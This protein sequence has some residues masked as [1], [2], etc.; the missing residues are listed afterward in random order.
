MYS[1]TFII[2]SLCKSACKKISLSNREKFKISEIL[3]AEAEKED[4]MQEAEVQTKT[5]LGVQNMADRHQKKL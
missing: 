3:Q 2:K 1:F 5:I 4:A